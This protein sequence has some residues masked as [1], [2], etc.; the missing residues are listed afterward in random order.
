MKSSKLMPC[1]GND[2][3]NVALQII[4]AMWR[5]EPATVQLKTL[6]D[7][8]V[9]YDYFTHEVLWLKLRIELNQTTFRSLGGNRRR[10]S[11]RTRIHH[12]FKVHRFRHSILRNIS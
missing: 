2:T 8:G 12:I 7:E 3:N 9:W 4:R 11:K 10:W 5:D 1:P 6:C